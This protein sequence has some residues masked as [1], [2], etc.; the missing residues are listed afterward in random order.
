MFEDP[1]IRLLRQ[2]NAGVSAA[3]N[4]GLTA[5]NA[6]AVLFLDGDDWLSPDALSSLAEALRDTQRTIAAV[7]PWLRVASDGGPD[8]GFLGAWGGGGVR[9]PES[10]DLLKSLMVRNLFANGGHLL[11]RR[12]ALESAGTF[13]PGLTYGEDWEYWTRLARL[14][15]FAAVRSPA[16]L[17]FVRERRDGVFHGMATR[18]ESFIPCMEAIF[19]AP[20]LKSRFSPA[21]L[22]SLR[23]RAEAENDW[24]VGRELIR[25][26][27]GA[28]GRRYLRRSVAAAPSLKRLALLA[29]GSLPMLRIGPFRSYALPNTA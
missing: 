27:K 15:L 22:A 1:R 26:G 3:R 18:P 2:R 7:G 5:S 14:G 6:D 16:P 24:I 21:D 9:R 23:H 8:G 28:D 20:A 13:N 17:L 12:H 29:A 10:G 4:L 11:I 25:H 19:Q